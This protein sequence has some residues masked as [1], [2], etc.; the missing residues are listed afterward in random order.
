MPVTD[1]L[2]HDPTAERAALG[3]AILNP[4]YAGDVRPTWFYD[5]RLAHLA[6]ALNAM[7]SEGRPISETT[8]FQRVQKDFSM[9]LPLIM[10]CT[11][12]DASPSEFD[13]WRGI[14]EDKCRRRKTIKAAQTFLHHAPSSNGE[15]ETLVTDLERDIQLD[16]EGKYPTCNGKEAALLLENHLIKRADTKGTLSGIS[17][18]IAKLDAMTDGLQLGEQTLIAARPSRG[19]T[20]IAMCIVA[21]ACLLNKIPTL[22]VSLEMSRE[23]LMRRLLSCTERIEMKR[24]KEGD[25]NESDAFALGRIRNKVSRAP[26]FIVEAVEGMNSDQYA[27]TVR[28]YVRQHGAKFVVT[29]Y[30]QKIESVKRHEK[31]TYEVG[32]VSKKLRGLAVSTKAAFLTLAQLNRESEKDKGRMPRLSDM[33]DSGQIER[34]AD[35]VGLLHSSKGKNDDEPTAQLIIA[36]QR[37]GEVG[38]IWLN[39]EPQFCLFTDYK[40]K[41]E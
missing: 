39:W 41:P 30:L 22:V 29:D 20:A 40:R 23:A 34:D 24:L 37:D 5:H 1:E 26:L 7:A 9:A 25:L 18:G 31:K 14:L 13:H 2:P 15:F 4:E 11:Q 10:E 28:R 35:T 19:K 3:C 38:P 32:D 36:K 12:S 33:A 21:H 17:T 6:H 8:L 16:I 27:A